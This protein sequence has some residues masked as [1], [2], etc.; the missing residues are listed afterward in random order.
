VD[1]A[2]IVAMTPFELGAELG[3]PVYIWLLDDAVIHRPSSA[4]TEETIK[5]FAE[6][7]QRRPLKLSR[8]TVRRMSDNDADLRAN[9]P[10]TQPRVIK[11]PFASCGSCVC[12]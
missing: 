11:T 5:A 1:T 8:E 9:D 6:R 3:R 4:P 10:T 12:A 7:G 2:K